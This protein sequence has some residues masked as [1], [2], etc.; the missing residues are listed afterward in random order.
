MIRKLQPYLNRRSAVAAGIGAA[1]LVAVSVV[2]YVAASRRAEEEKS[3]SRF[4]TVKADKA[5]VRTGPGKR[6]PVRWVFVQ[7]GVPVEIVAEY[8]NW[9]EIKDWEGQEG[10]IHV[11]ML[12][13]KRSV[14]VT[15]K[16]R[17]LYQQADTSS[18]PVVVLEPGIVAEVENCGKEWCQVRVRD[19]RGWLRRGEFWGVDPGEVID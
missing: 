19:K 5:N 1:L 13:R 4:V 3:P 11:A 16:K 14:I 6:Y 9:R 18:P 2:I 8:D 17:T 12:S 15:G 7:R 10:W